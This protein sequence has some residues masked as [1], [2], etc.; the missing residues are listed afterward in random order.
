MDMNL[1]DVN[2]SEITIGNRHRKDMGEIAGLAR[3]IEEIGLLQPIGITPDYRLVFGER[4]LRAYE[5]LGRTSIPARIV[6]VASIAKG[7]IAETIMRKAFTPS[8]LVAVVQTL[9]TFKH[10]GDRRSEQARNCA[11]EKLTLDEAARIVGWSRDT[12]NRAERVV[13]DGVP[14]LVEAMES[15][16]LSN[17][18]SR[19]VANWASGLPLR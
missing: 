10:G 7:E 14:E 3:S 16:R 6:D 17:V 13:K 18:F 4:R 12:Y 19:S 11:D 1:I 8:E 9:R 2:I 5:M 15:G